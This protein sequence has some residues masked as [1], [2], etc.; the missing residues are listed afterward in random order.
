M[1]T[2]TITLNIDTETGDSSAAIVAFT[3][4]LNKIKERIRVS[5][6][7]LDKYS[8]DTFHVWHANNHGAVI[9]IG[10]ETRKKALSDM[11]EEARRLNL[12]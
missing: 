10:P 7:S 5:N 3:E 6:Y 8:L 11:A 9:I 2:I 1:S 12:D 4:M